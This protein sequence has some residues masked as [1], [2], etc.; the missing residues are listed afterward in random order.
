MS[1]EASLC[2]YDNDL[3][4]VFG[5]R[6]FSPTNDDNDDGPNENSEPSSSPAQVNLNSSDLSDTIDFSSY[7]ATARSFGLESA[8]VGVSIVKGE[9]MW[10]RQLKQPSMPINQVGCVPGGDTCF[11]TAFPGHLEVFSAING[12]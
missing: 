12:E 3:L 7:D 8:L 11:V 1:S 10:R 2:P 9:E 6:F 4:L 5:V